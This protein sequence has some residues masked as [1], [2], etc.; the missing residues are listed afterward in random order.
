MSKTEA[1][2][3]EQIVRVQEQFEADSDAFLR[4]TENL[5][6]SDFQLI[7]KLIQHY[8]AAD[9]NAR[10]IIDTL[11]H[12]ALGPDKR[13]GGKLQ[14]AQVLPKL[15]EAANLL[16]ESS[17]KDG[18]KKATHG[19]ELHRIHRHNFAHWVARRVPSENVLLLFTANKREAEKRDGVALD[20]GDLKY[21]VVP[22][23]GFDEAI[24]NLSGHSN[25]LAQAAANFEANFDKIQ[26]RFEGA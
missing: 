18:I 12:A 8:C 4:T 11:R 1:E 2:L 17:W 5:I 21:A 6:D 20:D 25:Y 24:E 23:D 15:V 22:L 14:D 16:W 3:M 26:K 13:Y 9:L 19:I 7:G 10:R